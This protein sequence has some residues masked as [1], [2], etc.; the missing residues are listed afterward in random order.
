MRTPYHRLSSVFAAMVVVFVAACGGGGSSSGSP[1]NTPPPPPVPTPTGAQLAAASKV[2]SHAT[3]GLAY[4]DIYALAVAGRQAWLDQQF[5]LGPTLHKP[6]V[7]TLMQMLD[8]NELPAVDDPVEHLI[9]FRRYAWWNRAMTAPDVLR[10]RVAFAL[11]EILVVSDNV[12][13][14]IV[15]PYALSTYYDVLLA[16]AF[17]NYRDLLENVALHPAMGMYLSHVNNAKAN[18]GNNTFPD[19]NF[20]RE[21]MQLFSIGLFE[22]NNDGSVQLGVN[23]QPIPTYDNEDVREMA[24]IFTGLSY[25]GEGAF[26]GNPQPFFQ[27]DMQMFEAAHELGEKRLLNG[28]VV[29]AG[30]TGMQDIQDALDNLFNHPNV[31]P[32]IGKQLIQRLVTSNPSP[33]YISRI[34]ST[35]NGAG[36]GIRGD[37]QATIAAILSDPEATNISSSIAAGRL[38]EPLVRFV[39]MARQL[40]ATAEDGLFYNNGFLQQFALRQHPLSSPSVF[41]FFLPSHSPTGEIADARLQAPE[42]QITDASTIISMSNLV[43]F[44]VSADFV[45]DIQ[46]PFGDVSL[47]LSEFVT[48]AQ[49]GVEPLLDRL[50]LVFTHGQLSVTTRGVI[51]A[52]LADIND[53]EF[54]ARTAIYLILISPDYAVDV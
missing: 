27:V 5:A 30:Q 10:Q 35:F 46:E 15:Y 39:S 36:T 21:L 19:E 11:S 3:F 51:A 25:G 12:D 13:A 53:P 47:N 43:D 23:G 45:M 9:M 18:P 38:R 54:Q 34:A 49:Q 28:L 41:N 33:A 1:E 44:A 2:A 32:F 7:D 29:G 50:D 37:M 8:N 17:G 14:L 48:L 40:N 24:K 42:F 20:A 16:H 31:G 6:V 4:D 26:F 22:L 52:I